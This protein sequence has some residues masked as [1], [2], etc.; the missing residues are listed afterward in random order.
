MADRVITTDDRPND[1]VIINEDRNN[2][3]DAHKSNTLGKV[4]AVIALAIIL[5]MLLRIPFGDSDGGADNTNVNAPSPTTNLP[6]AN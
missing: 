4:L 2:T 6:A 1:T 3:N 5:L